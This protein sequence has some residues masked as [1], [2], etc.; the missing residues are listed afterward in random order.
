MGKSIKLNNSIYWDAS[1]IQ[2]PDQKKS[3]KTLLTNSNKFTLGATYHNSNYPKYYLLAKLPKTSTSNSAMLHLQGFLGSYISNGK[4]TFDIMVANRD[5]INI[6]GSYSG[7][8][9]AWDNS[10]FAVY[11]ESSGIV[12]VYFVQ[13]D[14]YT[15]GCEINVDG[16]NLTSNNCNYTPVTPTGTLSYKINTSNLVHIQGEAEKVKKLAKAHYVYVAK[17]NGDNEPINWNVAEK[18]NYVTM[19]TVVANTNTTFFKPNGSGHI[20]IGAGVKKVRAYGQAILDI[21]NWSAS[22]YLFCRISKNDVGVAKSITSELRW[23]TLYSD[24][25]IDV[26]E[27]DV[28]KFELRAGATTAK[29]IYNY[30]S[31]FGAGYANYFIVE[32]IEYDL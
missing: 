30:V 19:T 22:N 32:A 8:A 15:G 18:W 16:T 21:S 23:V 25:I 20:V 10:Y 14:N 13:N 27:G 2:C 28:L 31:S 3:L 4:A 12:G 7:F 11:T 6:R 9:S 5:G 17:N 24:V 29:A 1:G 26:A